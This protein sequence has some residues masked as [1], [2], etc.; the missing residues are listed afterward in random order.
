MPASPL[1]NDQS[2]AVLLATG[3]G[4]KREGDQGGG[5]LPE[6]R[7]RTVGT[8]RELVHSAG[9]SYVHDQY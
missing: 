9:F 5:S 2:Q 3:R 7:Y 4:E 8:R 6:G 1:N